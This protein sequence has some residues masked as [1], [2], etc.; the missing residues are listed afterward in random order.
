MQV[1]E[2]S[3]AEC[4]AIFRPACMKGD[5][6]MKNHRYVLLGILLILLCLTGCDKPRNG[7]PERLVPKA[8]LDGM[9][10]LRA[11]VGLPGPTLQESLLRSIK[12]E[13]ATDYPPDTEGRRFYPV[14]CISG[15]SANGAYG[16][17]FLKGWSREGSRPLF[18][19]VTGV[20]TGALTA[21]MAFLGKNYDRYLEEMYT[22][23]STKDVMQNRGYLAV[24]TGNSMASSRPLQVRIEK[25][26][27]DKILERFAAEHK[28]GRRLYVGTTLLDAQL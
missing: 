27:D 2:K 21:P 10:G 26:Y 28:R 25:Y 5:S 20:S 7:V 14:L 8:Q 15:G 13:S 19:V 18:K 16:A 9:P 3:C 4:T 23:I 12:E 17:G 24:A 11:I 6:E 1:R 22:T